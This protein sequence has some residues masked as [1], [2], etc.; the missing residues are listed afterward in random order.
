MASV[1]MIMFILMGYLTAFY[2]NQQQPQPRERDYFYVGA[3]FVYGL[4]IAIGMRGLFDLVSEKVKEGSSRKLALAAVLLLGV[5]FV[6]VRMVQAN[7]F[8]HDRSKNWVPWDYSYNLLQSASENAI[9]FTNGDNDTF[10]LWYLQ[11]VEG[12]R[13][14]VRIANLSLLNTPWYIKQLKNTEPHGTPKVKMSLTDEQI[15]RIA[16][17]QWKA[18]RIDIPIEPETFKEFGI[19]DTGII[20]QGKISWVMESTVNFGNINAVRAQDIVAM[21]IVRSN[22]N[23]RPVY[24][25]VT[26]PDNSKIGLNDYLNMEGLSFR[27]TPKKYTDFYSAINPEI[28]WKQLMEEPEGYSKNYQPGFKFRGLNDSTIFMDE[29]HKRLTLNYRNSY[30]RLSLYYLYSERNN[31]KTVQVLDMMEQ[32]IPRKLFPIDYRLLNDV[33]STYYSAGAVDKYKELAYEIEAEAL[34][35][36]EGNPMNLSGDYN[37]YF[38]LKQIYDNLGEYGKFLD[39]LQRLKSMAPNDPSV[40]KLIEDYTKLAN[41]KKVELP[42]PSN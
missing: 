24:F 15:D 38:V 29:N 5:I 6:P 22:I 42:T 7:Y 37:P 39:I 14:D 25:A 2:Q 11:D 20:K 4:W 35:A 10:P 26:T 36:I 23:D 28:M 13:R 17:S 21:D 30:I 8:T 16:P 31:E 3:F 12:V 9:I 18:R 33:A 40:D 32:K 41:Q 34:R 1:F 19:T 27:V